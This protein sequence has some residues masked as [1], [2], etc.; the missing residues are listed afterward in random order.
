MATLKYLERILYQTDDDWPVVKHDIKRVQ[1]F[2]EVL[3]KFIIMEGADTRVAGIF[4]RVVIQVVLLFDFYTWL[5][6]VAM[7]R[8]VEGTHTG[9]LRQITRYRKQRKSYGTWVTPRVEVFQE[10]AVTQLEM[11]YIGRRQG[12]AAQWMALRP[13]FEVY[14]REKGYEGVG[15]RR[16]SWWNQEAAET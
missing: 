8:T 9:F 14:A 10:A 16:E 4:Y 15:C 12:M 2:Q 11:T 1:K 3:G 5:L 7:E 6:S 13:I